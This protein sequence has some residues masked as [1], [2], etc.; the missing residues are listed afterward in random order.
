MNEIVD[1]LDA[2]KIAATGSLWALGETLIPALGAPLKAALGKVAL[3][4]HAK[5][6]A[7]TAEKEYEVIEQ[8]T[9]GVDVRV[10]KNGNILINKGQAPTFRPITGTVSRNSW[11]RT[12]SRIVLANRAGAGKA[13]RKI[14]AMK[15]SLGISIHRMAL[16]LQTKSTSKARAIYDPKRQEY[17]FKRGFVEVGDLTSK[18]KKKIAKGKETKV[19][20]TEAE[21]IDTTT[22]LGERVAKAVYPKLTVVPETDT[23]KFFQGSWKERSKAEAA[24]LL[25][26]VEA[27]I[28]FDGPNAVRIMPNN[29]MKVLLKPCLSIL[30]EV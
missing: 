9:K 26:P 11:I 3:G 24:K 19:D 6:T 14:N 15:Q 10:D 2:K 17:D 16:S 30:K 4:K 23:V 20:V 28:P 13:I 18:Q 7:K 5:H 25:E 27:A 1:A 29:L 21:T 22:G 12:L 8:L